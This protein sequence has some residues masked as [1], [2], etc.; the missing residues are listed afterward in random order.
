MHE[1]DWSENIYL[2]SFFG[3]ETQAIVDVFAAR[4]VNS[5]FDK[6]RVPAPTQWNFSGELCSGLAIDEST[7]IN[8]INPGLKCDCT[9][10]NSTLCHVTGL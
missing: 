4:I 1:I 7:D 2:I 6:L 9:Y 10:N 8:D 3:N 5:I